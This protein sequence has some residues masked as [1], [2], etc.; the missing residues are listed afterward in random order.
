MY[1]THILHNTLDFIWLNT[2]IMFNVIHLTFCPFIIQSNIYPSFHCAIFRYFFV[3]FFFVVLLCV[4]LIFISLLF[5]IF[6]Y[7][8][9]IIL[10][11]Y[12]IFFFALAGMHY[13]LPLHAFREFDNW[14][15]WI[16]LTAAIFCFST[17]FSETM[18]LFHK[19]N[20]NDKCNNKKN[21]SE[22]SIF[23]MWKHI[24]L[25]KTFV[26]GCRKKKGRKRNNKIRCSNY[27]CMNMKAKK[28]RRNEKKKTEM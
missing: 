21:E 1:F 28:K 6:N 24:H 8:C 17:L 16:E 12:S 22:T 20:C 9:T 26:Y 11:N 2:K 19:Q 23:G 7:F 3:F 13:S 14:E 10:K 18:I 27:K 15:N 4:L 25:R 5:Y